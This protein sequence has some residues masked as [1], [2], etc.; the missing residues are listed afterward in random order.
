MSSCLKSSL[1]RRTLLVMAAGSLSLIAACGTTP[2]DTAAGWSADK[3][4]SEAK[5]ESSAGNYDRA[6]RLY[7][8]LEG[9]AS[10]SSLSQQAQLEKAFLQYKTGEKAAA[11][12]TLERFIKFNP[13][14]PGLDYAYY[15]QGLANFNDNVGFLGQFAG[16][17]MAERDQQA[18]RDAL[19]SFKQV[20]DLFPQSRYAEDS[21]TRAAYILD[22]LAAYEV[23]VARYYY[24]RGAFL[25]A[26]NRAQ[27]AIQEFQQSPSSEEALGLLM[28]SYRQLGMNDLQKDAERILVANF[29]K[30][31]Y[32]K[33]DDFG[34]TDRR[35]WQ[36]W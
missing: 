9:R 22:S 12:A 14:S 32:L 30:S 2:S 19:Q 29:P 17:D 11:L 16:Q 15:L 21:R 27:T 6:I 5:E 10:G 25:A 34:R 24:R 36:F 26:A 20:I 23:H 28:H 3:L 18:S 31:Q 8:R 7:E 1:W 13:T 33:S 35:W 4:Y